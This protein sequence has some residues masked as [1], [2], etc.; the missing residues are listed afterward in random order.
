ML[1]KICSK[2]GEEKVVSEFSKDKSKKD[3]HRPNCKVCNRK[4][5]KMKRLENP[6][7]MA[8]NLKEFY[9]KNPN[10]KN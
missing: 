9:K 8:K 1:T 4:Y 7:L 10:K 6:E 3:G 2:C 5:F